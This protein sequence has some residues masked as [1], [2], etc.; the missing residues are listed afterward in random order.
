MA[1]LPYLAAVADLQ[2]VVAV[3]D[4]P[5]AE[6][7]ATSAWQSSLVSWRLAVVATC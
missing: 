5:A 2:L 1:S 4:H 7:L 3:V 6:E